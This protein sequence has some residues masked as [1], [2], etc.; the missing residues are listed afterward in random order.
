[1]SEIADELKEA[2]S[3]SRGLSPRLQVALNAW[4]DR[5]EHQIAP[6]PVESPQEG[7][8]EPYSTNPERPVLKARPPS[9]T[10]PVKWD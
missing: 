4:I 5:V 8:E 10:L 1:M 6:I 3:M 9:E 7:S 2:I